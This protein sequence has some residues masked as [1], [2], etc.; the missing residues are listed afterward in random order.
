MNK[1]FLESENINDSQKGRQEF[2]NRSVNIKGLTT[3][4]FSE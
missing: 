4:I 1:S 2:E 3:F